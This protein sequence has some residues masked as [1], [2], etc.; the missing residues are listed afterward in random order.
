MDTGQAIK[1]LRIKAGLTQ[2]QLADRCGMSVSGLSYL[3]T[4][5]SVP[6]KA[7]IEKLCTA[8]DIPTSYFLLSSIEESDLPE[9]KRLL[10]R[11][12]LEELR[13]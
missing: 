9:E 6:P 4:G 13:K 12:L 10:Y 11:A 3:E 7:T 1:T 5:R 8:L 2:E